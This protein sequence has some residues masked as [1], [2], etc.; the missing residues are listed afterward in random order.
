MSNRFSTKIC[1]GLESLSKMQDDWLALESST[2]THPFSGY[3]WCL[4]QA[5][6]HA[7]QGREAIVVCV[8]ENS[9]CIALLPLVKHHISRKLKLQCLQ[10][11]CSAFTD[12]QGFIVEPTIDALMLFQLCLSQLADSKYAKLPII[13]RYPS[14]QLHQFCGLSQDYFGRQL[15]FNHWRHSV[16]NSADT[17]LNGKVLREAR[18]RRKKLE[19]HTDCKIL[20]NTPCDEGLVNW[21]LD[22]NAA[23]FGPNQLTS[24]ANRQSVQ[25][26]LQSYQSSL[27]LSVI[28]IEDKP[29]AAHLGFLQGSTLQYYLLAADN[30][31]R[32]FSIGIVL[33]NEIISTQKN[34]TDIDYL[35]GDEEYK[36]DW[37]NTVTIDN[38]VIC[39]P[40][41]TNPITAW[42]TKLYAK[43]NQ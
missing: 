14:A 33:L 13:I 24:R 16:Y 21:V 17:P 23:R 1:V 26:L 42:F 35:R 4:N 5:Q 15:P 27:H 11:L 20:I 39:L 37:A 34:I 30:N 10:H 19:Q 29:A 40:H 2:N 9:R 22:Q 8:Y 38:G 3:F 6:L 31:F 28:T 25:Q 7:S 43:R 41:G 18:R 12:Y 32:Q 36:K